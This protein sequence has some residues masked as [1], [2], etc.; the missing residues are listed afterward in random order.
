MLH[1]PGTTLRLVVVGF[2]V[3]RNIVPK[4]SLK[5]TSRS[6]DLQWTGISVKWFTLGETRTFPGRPE[7]TLDSFWC[8]LLCLVLRLFRLALT[9]FGKV[10]A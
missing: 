7:T 3:W 1:K 9:L 5:R 4:A 10:L 6:L 2:G 8:D